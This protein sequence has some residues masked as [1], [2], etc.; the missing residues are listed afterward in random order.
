MGA[1][2]GPSTRR[3]IH[4]PAEEDLPAPPRPVPPGL[5]AEPDPRITFANERTFLAWNRTALALIV[6]GL[7]VAQFLR[8]G[9]GDAQL[10][11]GLALIVLGAVMSASSY[12]LWNRNKDA[13]ARGEPLPTSG[14][15][16]VLVWAIGVIA[17]V[18]VVL[19]IVQLASD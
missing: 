19:V 10:L 15:P 3:S 14:L 6:G 1:E 9:F 7:A 2:S 4:G 5:E 16:Q 11:V 18:S 13:L 8:L 17:L 12:R